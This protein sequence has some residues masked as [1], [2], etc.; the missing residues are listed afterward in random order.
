[1][2]T[3]T[4]IFIDNP[5]IDAETLAEI[6]RSNAVM[7]DKSKLKQMAKD[8]VKWR[9][10]RDHLTSHVVYKHRK[11]INVKSGA[12][13]KRQ[14]NTPKNDLP[15]QVAAIC[16]PSQTMPSISLTFL[17]VWFAQAGEPREFSRTQPVNPKP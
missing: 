3:I 15:F 11:D 13:A 5:V 7:S 1:V 9:E 10:Y 8:Q 14:F 2:D 4:H 17:C 12:F 6:R 16:S